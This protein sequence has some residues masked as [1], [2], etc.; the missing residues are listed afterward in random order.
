[1]PEKNDG[2][3]AADRPV[4]RSRA[5]AVD[6]AV[7]DL[8]RPFRFLTIAVLDAAGGTLD[9][10]EG[11]RALVDAESI[12]LGAVSPFFLNPSFE[13]IVEAA[14]RQ[15]FGRILDGRITVGPGRA[16]TLL[17]AFYANEGLILFAAEHDVAEQDRVN[18]LVLSLNEDL[19]TAQRDLVKANQ[20]IA[21]RERALEE[22]AHTD[23]LT[24]L[25]NRR[26]AETRL[27][28]EL[29]RVQR[30]GRPLSIAL[31]D[32]DRFKVINDE[33]GHDVGDAALIAI[34]RML[35]EY[36]R[37]ADFVARWGGEEFMLLLPETPLE[38]AF[39][40]LDR[41]RETVSARPV[42]PLS[43]SP[44]ISIGVTEVATADHAETMFR[45][46][47]EAL[48]EAKRSGRNRVIV[49]PPG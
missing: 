15:P 12:P 48:Y 10:N 35:R 16:R 30:Y 34:G 2:G 24:G 38:T 1:M 37:Q 3:P 19:A 31:A 6:S 47:D 32:I 49:R 27:K 46:A 43:K 26:A 42:P 23:Q 29:A 44:T 25:P 36:S 22:I 8:L 13:E 39:A 7:L 45:R 41:L 4:V 21:R 20:S 11:F 28:S 17:G 9:C 14:R 40:L 18:D 5:T 33:H